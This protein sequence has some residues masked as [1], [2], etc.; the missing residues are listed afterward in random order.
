MLTVITHVEAAA[1]IRSG[2]DFCGI[3]GLIGA[4]VVTFGSWKGTSHKGPA[5]KSLPGWAAGGRLLLQLRGAKGCLPRPQR[6]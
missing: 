6:L 5:S 1:G 3:I 4:E 2:T